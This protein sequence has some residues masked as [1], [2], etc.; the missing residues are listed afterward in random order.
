MSCEMKFICNFCG[1]MLVPNTLTAFCIP[2]TCG[3]TDRAT[4]NLRARVD[5]PH[6]CRDCVTNLV[7]FI[8]A[9]V[10]EKP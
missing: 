1:G 9:Q 6:I 10:K 5:G 3:S 2:I 7:E 8:T 4:D